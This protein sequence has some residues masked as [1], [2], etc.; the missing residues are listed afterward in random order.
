MVNRGD[1][2]K[3]GNHRLM[4]GDCTSED[5]MSRLTE[6][7]P[8]RLTVTSP[9]YGV[10]KEYENKGIEEW[11]HLVKNAIPQ[12]ARCSLIV[13]WNIGDLFATGT[14]FIEPTSTYSINE[15]EKN[16]FGVMYNRIWKKPGANFRGQNPYHLVSMKPVQEYEFIIGFGRKNYKE[17]Y[18]KIREE[19][20]TEAERAGITPKICR[21]ITGVGMFGHWFRESEWCLIDEKNYEKIKQYCFLHGVEA[22]DRPWKEYREWYEDLSLYSTYLTNEERREFGNWAIWHFNTVGKRENH[23]AAF[24]EELPYRL[25]KTHTR[26]GHSVMDP[27]GG[28]GTTLIVAE[29]LNRKSFI[30]EKEPKYCEVII[31]RAKSEL[32]LVASAV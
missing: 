18:S 31:E 27:F 8:I 16:G 26:E 17:S 15:F 22:F 11:K 29:K 32:G 3:I 4:C 7:K 23:P 19:L 21:D 5:D 1:I 24:P 13:C 20:S 2:F 12:I 6:S 30:M 9:P 14:Q 10:G 28:S 25:I